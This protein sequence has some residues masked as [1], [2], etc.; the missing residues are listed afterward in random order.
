MGLKGPSFFEYSQVGENLRKHPVQGHR[1]PLQDFDSAPDHGRFP[2]V[3][4]GPQG[5]EPE[6][7][8]IVRR[9]RGWQ[10][11]VQSGHLIMRNV[12]KKAEGDMEIL[13]GYPACPH[14][15]RLK[16]CLVVSEGSTNSFR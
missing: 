15:R 10:C 1:I 4:K 8:G 9:Q 14:A 7:E 13:R 3:W 5:V 12:A 2:G 6:M 11:V 16:G